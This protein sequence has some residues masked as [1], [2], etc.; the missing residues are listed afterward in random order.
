MEKEI[1][2][3]METALP[4]SHGV[5]SASRNAP[6]KSGFRGIEFFK[7]HRLFINPRDADQGGGR[8]RGCQGALSI[9]I[10]TGVWRTNETGS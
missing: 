10:S 5:P 6:G 9:A 4:L 8:D 7:K 1:L 2:H 3:I